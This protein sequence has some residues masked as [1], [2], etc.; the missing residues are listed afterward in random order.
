MMLGL[1]SILGSDG[2]KRLAVGS[3]MSLI[4]I[5]GWEKSR[6][7]KQIEVGIY[8]QPYT[9]SVFSLTSRSAGSSTCYNYRV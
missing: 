1:L 5:L 6:Y 8:I 3:C 7:Y 4:G 9:S 2:E